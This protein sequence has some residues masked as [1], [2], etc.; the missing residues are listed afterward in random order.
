MP[1]PV[2]V[3]SGCPVL[4]TS[5]ITNPPLHR[6]AG[7][8]RRRID[9]CQFVLVAQRCNLGDYD[10][11]GNTAE[12][13]LPPSDLAMASGPLCMT[14]RGDNRSAQVPA[15]D[16]RTLGFRPNAPW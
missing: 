2:K 5:K 10:K 15:A 16:E 14:L 11:E 12:Q 3:L 7:G 1:A 13:Y 6:L 4:L 8:L 9:A